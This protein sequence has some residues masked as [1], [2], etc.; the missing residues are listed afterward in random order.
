MQSKDSLT[1]PKTSFFSKSPRKEK[2]LDA[3]KR[4]GSKENKKFSFGA[5]TKLSAVPNR[6][7][8]NLKDLAVSPSE[9]VPLFVQK[10]VQFVE[11]EGLNAEGIYRVPGNQAHVQQLEQKFLEGNSEQ[12]KGKEEGGAG[13]T[14]SKGRS[15]PPTVRAGCFFE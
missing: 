11:R 15:G 2:D 5:R 1:A 6:T 8:A 14:G 9:P 4:K 13:D 12:G 7:P 10:C 3:G